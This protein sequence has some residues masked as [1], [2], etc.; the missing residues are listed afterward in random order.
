[1][2][3]PRPAGT[4]IEQHLAAGIGQLAG[5]FGVLALA[6][7][8]PAGLRAPDQPED[9]HS[10]FGQFAED[11]ADR[12]SGPGKQFLGV[13]AEVGE[14]DLI[15]RPGTAQHLMQAAEV[16]GPVD[17]R[18][19]QIPR[20]PA[21]DIGGRVATLGVAEEPGVDTG[22]LLVRHG[23]QFGPTAP[24]RPDPFGGDDV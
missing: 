16:P 7:V 4:R 24:T 13:A 5:Q 12:R 19:D 21:T 6:L 14:I 22:I 8:E 15:L 11:V 2:V 23:G 3:R 9:E 17:Q 1:M 20:R 10:S 18:F